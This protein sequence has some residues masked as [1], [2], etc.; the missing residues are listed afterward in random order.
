MIKL[1][2]TDVDGVLTDNGMYYTEFGD[3]F[4]KFNTRDGMG[5][6][7]LR[8]RNIKT[9]IIT[10]EVTK[11]VENRAK[12]LKVDYLYQGK[13]YGGKL[14]AAQEIC[15]NEGIDLSEAVYIGDDINCEELLRNVGFAACPFDAHT[16]IKSI[17]GIKIMKLKGGEGVVRELIDLIIK[18]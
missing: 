12:K 9:G 17:P 18:I 10:S 8:E 13:M 6:Q 5:F 3:E 16:I 7:L 1:F 4:K 11:I 2:L 14:T 15:L